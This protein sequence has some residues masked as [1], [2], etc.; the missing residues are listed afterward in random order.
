M[1][2]TTNI[3][4]LRG[5]E[6]TPH[7]GRRHPQGI[8]AKRGDQEAKPLNAHDINKAQEH[9][10]QEPRAASEEATQPLRP[11]KEPKAPQV[12]EFNA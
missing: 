2:T 7:T 3:H 11:K 10:A 1:V 8:Q 4:A 9:K 6:A 5:S 12:K